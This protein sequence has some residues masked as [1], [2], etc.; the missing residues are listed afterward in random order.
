MAYNFQELKNKSKEVEEHIK[1]E[2]SGVRTGR[3]TPAILDSILVE[4]Y[5]AK[6]P[7]VQVGNVSI[8]DARTLR[9]SPWDST[10]NK[11]IE[12]AII[13][14]NLGLSVVVD[15]S[16]V[17]VI[18]PELTEE[19]RKSLI[20]ILKEKLEEGKVRLRTARDHVWKDIQEKEKDGTIRED[21]KF[22]LKD[23][24]QKLI[25]GANK[26]LEEQFNKKEKEILG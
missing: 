6:V 10:H 14:S 9:I 23:E 13:A 4:S 1:K 21:E 12:K 5:G 25:D 7:I 2:F 16:G 26:N 11:E 18:F 24:M 8:E 15:D 20:K 17:R 22:R 3:A 19:R